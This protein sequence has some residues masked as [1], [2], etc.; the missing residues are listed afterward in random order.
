MTLTKDC[1][2]SLP[3][4]SQ[5]LQCCPSNI[6][7]TLVASTDSISAHLRHPWLQVTGIL[8]RMEALGIAFHAGAVSV[9][10]ELAEQR[11]QQLRKEAARLA[12]HDFNLSSSAQL[13]QVWFCP[14]AL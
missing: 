1:G 10:Q 5:H 11:L 7:T 2:G 4:P 8:A 3:T 12:G 9:H 6:V 13:A 14:W